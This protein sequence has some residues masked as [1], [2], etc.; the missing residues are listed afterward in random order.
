MPC[1]KGVD[2]PVTFRCYNE[3]YSETKGGARKEYLQCTA[4]R[5]N[6]SSASL[7]VGCGK[8]ETHCPQQI[9]IRKELRRAVRELETLP[10]K[11]AKKAIAA[12]RFLCPEFFAAPD[13]DVDADGIVYVNAWKQVRGR[14][15]PI[16][17]P[18]HINEKIISFKFGRTKRMTVRIHSGNNQKYRHANKQKDAKSVIFCFVFEK[19][20]ND[21][22][23]Y[24][25]KPQEIRDNKALYERNPIVHGHV[26]DMEAA[27]DCFFQPL[28]PGQINQQIKQQQAMPV[29]PENF[30]G[31][32]FRS[33]LSYG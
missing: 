14:I 17:I 8:C 7:C 2:I 5:Q 19:I 26:D 31:A 10:Y 29:F 20:I 3:M 15:D 21:C 6:Q 16:Q 23:G 12:Y 25:K 13:G 4:F 18:H 24:I 9:E 22:G 27:G 11:A 32:V 30:T 28:K 33:T 1:P